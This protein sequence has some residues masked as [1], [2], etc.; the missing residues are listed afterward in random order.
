[1]KAFKITS[2]AAIAGILLLC[3]AFPINAAAGVI[4]PI[5]IYHGG[6]HID[7]KGVIAMYLVLNALCIIGLCVRYF[8]IKNSVYFKKQSVLKN[9]FFELDEYSI[10][11]Q[12]LN[13]LSV[14]IIVL[15]GL[16]LI[17]IMVKYVAD[18]I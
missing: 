10:I 14:F 17:I 13:I 18:V 4:I 6:G 7:P 2:V 5:P 3:A 16:A 11:K 9:I 1:M 15:N 8:I 12:D